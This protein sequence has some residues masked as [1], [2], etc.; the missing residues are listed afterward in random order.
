VPVIPLAV[1]VIVVV[2]A[3]ALVMMPVLAPMGILEFEDV[4]VAPVTVCP[5]L[6]CAWKVRVEPAD[7]VNVVPELEVHPTAHKIVRPPPPPVVTVKVVLPLCPL[8]L[9]VI[10][11]VP[12]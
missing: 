12:V 1:A 4:H 3:E 7:A 8:W 9:A 11:V 10:V 6:S 2:P 5:E